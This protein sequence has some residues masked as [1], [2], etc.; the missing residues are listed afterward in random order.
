MWWKIVAL[1]DNQYKTIYHGNEGSRT[2]PRGVWLRADEKEVHDGSNGT[3]YI[4]GWHVIPTREEAEKYFEKFKAKSQLL[5]IIPV[6]AYNIVPK[7]HSRAPVY[8]A[9][10]IY[11]WREGD[12]YATRLT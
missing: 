5:T 11:I 8:L 10:W 3:P 12:P 7:R 2:L 6:F 1:D 9:R 4:S